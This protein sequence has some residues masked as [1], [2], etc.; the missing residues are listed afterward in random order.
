MAVK[1]VG[2]T[3]RRRQAL[4]TRAAVT[5][6]ARRLFAAHGYVATTIQAIADTADIPVQTIYSAFGSKPAILE[7]IRRKWIVDADVEVLYARALASPESRD[8]LRLAAHWTRRPFQ[9]RHDVIAVSRRQLEATRVLPPSG[10]KRSPVG[11]RPWP[12]SCSRSDRTCVR[13]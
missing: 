9:L 6:A 4:A 3:Y 5:E 8:R 1:P 12:S 13:D 10:G 2:P 7:E 11:K